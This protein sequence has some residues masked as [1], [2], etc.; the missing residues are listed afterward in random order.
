MVLDVNFSRNGARE[1]VEIQNRLTEDFS[2]SGQNLTQYCA[3][4][5]SVKIYDGVFAEHLLIFG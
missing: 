1:V 4:V 5:Q 3:H 2:A